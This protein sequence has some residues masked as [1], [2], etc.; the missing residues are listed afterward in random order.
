MELTGRTFTTRCLSNISKVGI[1]LLPMGLGPAVERPSGFG[2]I[3]KDVNLF[4]VLRAN[5]IPAPNQP[6]HAEEATLDHQVEEPRPALQ[7]S[8]TSAGSD[9]Q[10][11]TVR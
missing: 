10:P 1:A 7:A 5:L 4:P 9:T 11:R 6:D 2:L 8:G 3:R